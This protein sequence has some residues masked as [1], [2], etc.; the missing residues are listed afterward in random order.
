MS[1][2]SQHLTFMFREIL[3]HK[4]ERIISSLPILSHEKF[5]QVL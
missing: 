4:K 5:S 3:K 1:G 2:D